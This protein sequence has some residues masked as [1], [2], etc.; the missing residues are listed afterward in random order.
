M[1][2]TDTSDDRALS[3]VIGVILLVGITVVL[4]AVVGGLVI[5]FGDDIEVA[6]NVQLS[7]SFDTNDH[8]ITISHSSGDNLNPEELEVEYE[9]NRSAL[10]DVSD[11]G[12]EGLIQA[13]DEVVIEV[14]DQDNFD[15]QVVNSGDEFR[16]Y[17]IGANGGQN[18]ILIDEIVP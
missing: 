11:G 14:D 10:N 3:P 2:S 8:N 18:E 15:T 16:M 4:V 9:G 12:I 13:G 1:F 7:T 6:P 5:G 17:W